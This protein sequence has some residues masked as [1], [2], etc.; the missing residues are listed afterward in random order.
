M[1]KHVEMILSIA[2]L[3][4]GAQII[5]ICLGLLGQ[6]EHVS[7]HR[8]LHYKNSHLHITNH[9]SINCSPYERKMCYILFCSFHMRDS[10]P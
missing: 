6:S 10:A 9:L 1:R 5:I 4:N 3:E 8:D 2:Q 7:Q